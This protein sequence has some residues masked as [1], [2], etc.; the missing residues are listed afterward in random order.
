MK[1]GHPLEINNSLLGQIPGLLILS[2]SLNYILISGWSD[3]P[4]FIE[5][6]VL[7]LIAAHWPRPGADDKYIQLN[8][9]Y[10]AMVGRIEVP[11][12]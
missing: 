11:F 6:V 5:F 2:L 1:K 9:Y 7:L 10:E 12:P 3:L 4:L 8:K